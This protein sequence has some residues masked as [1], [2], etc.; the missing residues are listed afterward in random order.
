MARGN[1][2]GA[3]GQIYRNYAIDALLALYKDAS[4][5]TPTSTPSGPF[6]R[7]AEVTLERLGLPTDGIEAAVARRMRRLGITKPAPKDSC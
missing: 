1:R 5:K 3:P 7:L 6:M 4:G 2:G